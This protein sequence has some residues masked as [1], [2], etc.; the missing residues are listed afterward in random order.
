MPH[1]GCADLYPAALHV[2]GLEAQLLQEP[3]HDC[4]QPPGAD[5]LRSLVHLEGVFSQGLDRVVRK[6][7]GDALGIEQRLDL[8]LKLTNQELQRSVD[9]INGLINNIKA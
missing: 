9:F 4:V 7:D 5:I 8:Q 6:A 3:F 1:V 2:G